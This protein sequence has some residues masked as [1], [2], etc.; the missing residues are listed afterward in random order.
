MTIEAGT[1]NLAKWILGG[2]VA[3]A[4]VVGIAVA[5]Y[6]VGYHRGQHHNR[7]AAASPST[8][9][10]GATTTAAASPGTTVAATTVATTP[11]LVAHGKQ[12]YSADG[13]SACHSLTA[14]AGAGPGFKGLA[15][16]SV[17]L[18]NGE[19]VSAD[20]AYLARSI[21]DPDAEIVKGY[22]AGIMG[23]A[24][25]TFGLAGKPDDVR[26]LVAFIKSQK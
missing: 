6:A 20:D 7:G 17:T 22:H 8:T 21:A 9:T 19:T 14:A 11:A 13:C 4:A 3:G 25:S 15:G 18:D 1:Q 26:A 23:P 24:I 12:L 2:V 10:P 16:S 5:A